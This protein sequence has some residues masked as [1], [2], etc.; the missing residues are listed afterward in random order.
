MIKKIKKS[1]TIKMFLAISLSFIFVFAAMLLVQSQFFSRYYEAN[2]INNMLKIIDAFCSEVEEN[3]LNEDDLYRQIKKFGLAHNVKVEIYNK[4]FED[5]KDADRI[6]VT[7]VDERDKYWDFYIDKDILEE[8]GKDG[9]LALQGYIKGDETLIVTYADGTIIEEYDNNVHNLTPYKGSV[10]IV[11]KSDYYE[12]IKDR[13][14][15]SD[16]KSEQYK[17]EEYDIEY[18]ISQT[19]Y[20]DIKSVTFV[21]TINILASD[22]TLYATASLQP[23]DE[24]VGMLSGYIPIFLA[25]AIVLSIIIAFFYSRTVSRPIVKITK[26][27]NAMASMDFSVK[28]D[29]RRQDELGVLSR[30]INTLSDNL[31][32]ALG[33][34]QTA[35]VKLKEDYENEVRQENVRREFIANASHELKTPLGVV[36]SYVEAIRDNVKTEKRAYYFDVIM[37]ETAKMDELIMQML[38]LAR[39]EQQNMILNKQKID[40]G[41][42]IHGVTNRFETLAQEKKLHLEICGEYG[43]ANVDGERVKQ[44]LSNLIDNAVKYSKPDS[45]IKIKG[46]VCNDTIR[47]EVSNDCDPISED[48]LAKI[49]E[50]FYKVDTSHNRDMEGYGLGLSIVKKIFEMH[51]FEYGAFVTETGI[52]VWFEIPD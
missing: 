34:L 17:S 40:M 49:W 36:K 6:L 35:N 19:P 18:T 8:T 44:V 47:I 10:R 38:S 7:V 13:A 4:T 24:A 42:L 3:N 2:K 37:D 50:R 46:I 27:A 32:N 39:L 21:K 48:Q 51:G 15:Y 45:E 29:S 20:T 16:V 43:Y 28:E 11:D 31:E 25:F 52:A 22:T 12:I 41:K 5:K 1:L 26:T 9:T 30:S 14:K 23:V 33:E